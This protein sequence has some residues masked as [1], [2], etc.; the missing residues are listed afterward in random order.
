MFSKPLRETRSV[1]KNILKAQSEDASNAYLLTS[2]DFY[3]NKTDLK[4]YKMPEL[5][6]I[7]KQYNLLR[8][9]TKHILIERIQQHFTKTK[10]ATLIQKVFRGHLVRYSFLLRGDV[11]KN[12]SICVNETDFIT[13]EPLNEMPYE[14]FYSYKDSKNFVYG[15]NLSSLSNL[16]KQHGK[17]INPY[18]REKLSTKLINSIIILNNIT[19]IV[20]PEYHDEL[21]SIPTIR[22]KKA[23]QNILNIQ[24]NQ[25]I[26]IAIFEDTH[27]TPSG[28]NQEYSRP[29][30]FNPNALTNAD[31]QKYNHIIDI[32]KKPTLSRIQEVFMEIDQLGNYTQSNWFTDLD[33]S[34][35]IR[36][37]RCLH[38][39]WTYR[40]NLS[41]DTKRNICPLFDPFA[42]ILARSIYYTNIP[43]ETI[44]TLCITIVENLIYSGNDD[45]YRKIAALHVLSAL[46]V[47]SLPARHSMVWLYESISY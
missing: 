1:K 37:F 41:D 6:T 5:K 23:H 15:F 10:S 31:V 13:L 3:K 40:A 36:F 42:N 47:V 25:P 21:F 19:R 24:Q 26:A 14:M 12:R 22:S 33:T 27:D 35:Y 4:K 2:A 8:T 28:F 20:Y 30:L 44:Q 39:I 29:R 43:R 46:T 9:G 17:I 7:I 16:I 34:G 45:E 38:D 18:N 11:Y 32:R